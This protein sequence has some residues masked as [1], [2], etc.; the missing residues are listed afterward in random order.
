MDN[1]FG[2]RDA[3][4]APWIRRDSTVRDADTDVNSAGSRVAI[5]HTMDAPDDCTLCGG[6]PRRARRLDDSRRAR[7]CGSDARSYA[8]S[9]RH[10]VGRIQAPCMPGSRWRSPRAR[11]PDLRSLEACTAPPER[12]IIE[13][14]LASGSAPAIRPC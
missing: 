3:D 2:Y 5:A 13:L 9:S 7:E 1:A 6:E 4:G 8:S 14:H 10:D 12:L 11:N